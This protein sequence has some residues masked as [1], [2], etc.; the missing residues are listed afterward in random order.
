MIIIITLRI[1]TELLEDM[2][3]IYDIIMN[4]IEIDINRLKQIYW[5]SRQR[6][7]SFNKIAEEDP[8]M[9][10]NRLMILYL[11]KLKI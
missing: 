11:K 3:E 4:R 2:K 8:L 10:Y 9:S 5:R 1:K 6:N 7:W